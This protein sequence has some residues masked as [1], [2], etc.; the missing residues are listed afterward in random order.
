MT[1]KDVKTLVEAG[2]L[3][4][5]PGLESL[6]D[7]VLKMMNKGNS[8]IRHIALL[9]YGEKYSLHLSWNMLY[10]FPGE[11][12][13]DYEKLTE[14]L[15]L[16][17]HLPVPS[18]FF[19]IRYDRNNVY[20]ENPEK[21]SLK[22]KPSPVYDYCLPD[23]EE[24]IKN[25]AYMFVDESEQSKILAENPVYKK[26][27]NLVQHWRNVYLGKNGEKSECLDMIVFEDRIKI[28]DTREIK[29]KSRY[30][31]TGLAREIYLLCGE[32]KSHKTILETLTKNYGKDEIERCLNELKDWKLILNIKDEFLAL[33]VE[34]PQESLFSL[35][36]M[37]AG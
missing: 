16:I 13:E 15:P 1:D 33:A 20:W 10:G 26:V 27:N 11:K 2:F 21:Y 25:Y 35:L 7:S 12:I 32:P 23:D 17:Y 8:A 6:I 29:V 19:K 4:V 5:Q 28:F 30:D 22:L 37:N 14:L 31:L 3:E 36:F 34:R 9:K 18:G 24:F